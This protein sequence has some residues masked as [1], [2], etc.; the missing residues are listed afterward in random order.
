[1]ADELYIPKKSSRIQLDFFKRHADE[2]AKDLLGRI[3]VRE[4]TGKNPIYVQ[5]QEVAAYEGE[6]KSMAKGVL[7]SPG[8]IGVSTKFGKNLIDLS[9]LDI[10]EHSCVTLIA[11]TLFDKRGVRE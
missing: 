3:M 6:M 9:T 8:T 7:E 10:C 2:V 5:L 11:G 4:R 1:M